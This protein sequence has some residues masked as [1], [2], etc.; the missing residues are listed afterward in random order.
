MCVCERESVCVRVCVSDCVCPSCIQIYF[1]DSLTTQ[2]HPPPLLSPADSSE[3]DNSSNILE[4][5]FIPIIAAG[6]VAVI[7]IVLLIILT[8]VICC[9]CY[10]KRK[11]KKYH[12]E[13]RSISMTSSSKDSVGEFPAVSTPEL[14]RRAPLTEMA[15]MDYSSDD[16]E[17]RDL[18]PSGAIPVNLF[19]EH[20]E[21]FDQA[22]QLLFQREFDVSDDVIS[23][24]YDVI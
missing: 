21:K 17:E 18:I 2:S 15:V 14:C 7:L 11:Q 9:V 1:S 3:S 20:V 16:D 4:D 12:L 10:K 24:N 23:L 13:A 22:R 6:A 8:I 5:V 19:R